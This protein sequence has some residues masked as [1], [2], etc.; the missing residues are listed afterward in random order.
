M[1]MTDRDRL[2]PAVVWQAFL[3]TGVTPYETWTN[4]GLYAVAVKR[5]SLD[6]D[7]LET[8]PVTALQ[9]ACGIPSYDYADGF[10]FGFDGLPCWDRS[11]ADWYLGY[12]DGNDSRAALLEAGMIFE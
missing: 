8:A 7:L 3:E 10:R 12:L 2:T 5:G 6:K 1:N 4:C 9:L 11:N